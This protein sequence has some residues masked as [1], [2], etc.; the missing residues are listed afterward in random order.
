[1]NKLLISDTM[2]LIFELVIKKRLLVQILPIYKNEI[3]Q[4]LTEEFLNNLIKSKNRQNIYNYGYIIT[5]SYFF[6]NIILPSKLNP[7]SLITEKSPYLI[8]KDF[9][10]VLQENDNL[11]STSNFKKKILQRHEIISKHFEI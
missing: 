9:L 8:Y 1:M 6:E 2:R 11:L 4:M 3:T 7:S 5:N 10:K